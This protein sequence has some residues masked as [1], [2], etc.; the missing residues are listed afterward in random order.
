MNLFSKI[1]ESHMPAEPSRADGN[2]HKV[3]VVAGEASGDLHGSNLIRELLKFEPGMKMTGVG[4]VRLGAAG[5]ELIASVSEMAVVG[6]TE[7]FFRLGFILKIFFRLKAIF[8]REKPDLLILIDY[9]GFNLPLGKAAKKEGIKILY[10][11]SPQVW[12]SRRRRIRTIRRTIDRMAVIIPFEPALYARECVEATFV[13]H[14]LI[15]IVGKRYSREEALQR[16]KLAAGRKTI[17]ILPGSRPGEVS[18]LLPIML[19]TAR[20]LAEFIPTFSSSCPWLKRSTPL[21]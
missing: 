10:Y 7:V 9:S 8:K 15:D 5:V 12:A 21:R 19:E 20:I 2:R 4:G 16:F 14:P 1:C 3:V 18:R 17:G 6:L 11:I 13:G